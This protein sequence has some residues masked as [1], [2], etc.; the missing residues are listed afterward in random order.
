MPYIRVNCLTGA[1][2]PTRKA[3]M[4]RRLVDIV[5]GQEMSP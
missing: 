3:E 4:A 2:K 5:M 1:L